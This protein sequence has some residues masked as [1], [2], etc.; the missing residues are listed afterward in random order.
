MTADQ[1]ISKAEQSA[2]EY[3]DKTGVDQCMKLAYEVGVLRAEIK[4]LVDR[5]AFCQKERD[6]YYQQLKG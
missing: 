2:K 5:L 3:A 1:I 4:N 6:F